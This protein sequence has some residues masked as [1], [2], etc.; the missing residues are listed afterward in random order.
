MD[1]QAKNFKII[2]LTSMPDNNIYEEK[3]NISPVISYE[4]AG[5]HSLSYKVVDYF[6]RTVANESISVS[7]TGEYKIPFNE[8]LKRGFYAVYTEIDGAST[9]R[10]DLFSVVVN[11]DKRKYCDTFMSVDAA[12][13]FLL[14]PV[15]EQYAKALHLAGVT[16]VR[17]RDRE[18]YAHPSP[19]VY[20]F[21]VMDKLMNAY[22][23]YGIRVMPCNHTMP[24]WARTSK[25]SL[26]DDIRVKYDYYKNIA[27]RYNGQADYELWN[28]PDLDAVTADNMAAVLKAES[29]A[30]RDSGAD[31]LAVMPGIAA[32]PGEYLDLLMQNDVVKYFDTYSFHG[33]RIV[34]SED[35]DDLRDM[36][37]PTSWG[38]HIVNMKKYDL[39]HL[40][41]Y[42]TE[43]GIAT[44]MLDGKNYIEVN[45]QCAQARYLPTSFIQGASM[46]ADKHSYFLFAPYREAIQ[47]W[48]M[49][50]YTHMPYASYSALAALTYALGEAKYINSI[51]GLPQNVRGEVFSDGESRVAAFWSDCNT[52]ISV[53]TDANKGILIDIMGNESEIFAE[54]GFFKITA[55]PDISYLKIIGNFVG[56]TEKK[57]PDRNFVR[58]ELT[59]AERVVIEQKYPDELAYNAKQKG[60]RLPVDQGTTVT[61]KVTNFNERPMNGRIF[62]KLCGGW[63]LEEESKDIYIDAFDQVEL[64]FVISSKGEVAPE[65][66]TP[67]IFVG[68]FDGELTSRSV[69]HIISD[70]E[71]EVQLRPVIDAMKADKWEID[72][73][74]GSKVEISNPDD[75]TVSVSCSFGQGD[76]WLYPKMNLSRGD[77]FEGTKGMMFDFLVENAEKNPVVRIFAFEN[78][79]SGYFLA[80]AITDIAEGWNRIKIPWS[81]LTAFQGSPVDDNFTL[82]DYEINR[83]AIGINTKQAGPDIRYKLRNISVY[84]APKDNVFSEIVINS[85][86]TETAGEKVVIDADIIVKETGILADSLVFKIDGEKKKFEYKCGKIYSEMDLSAGKHEICIQFVDEYGCIVQNISSFTVCK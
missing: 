20:D 86:T 10:E 40:Y 82:D 29:I 42:N 7:G 9:G 38:R 32:A 37:I 72:V 74:P 61:V 69:T 36:K 56:A 68:E 6:G 21:T 16:H 83:I 28:E 43:A 48:G 62:G 15:I 11:A 2:G 31:C 22:G 80:D 34:A 46:G 5:E 77:S 50:T 59:C 23:K 49:F 47:Q 8:K 14:Q 78:N 1:N 58:H 79:G 73:L 55:S 60:Y 45:R 33:H 84:T 67:A 75:E 39:D 57:Y 64:T 17:E 13:Y 85:P 54:D 24:S 26:V 27:Q 41:F 30:L 65:L 44:S 70:S 3:D 18:H 66:K 81:S 53:K 19:D 35:A 12:G 51:P 52:D 71:G 25:F 4:G 76:K 63:M